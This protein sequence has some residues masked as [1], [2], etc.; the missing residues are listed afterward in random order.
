MDLA[1]QDG[2]LA[3]TVVRSLAG[4]PCRLRYGQTTKFVKAR[5]GQE[6]LWDGK[7]ESEAKLIE[8]DP[9]PAGKSNP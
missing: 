2:K 8:F 3:S 4:N 9:A 1:W 7:S 5:K 6:I